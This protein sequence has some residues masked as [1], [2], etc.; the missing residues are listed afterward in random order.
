M[1]QNDKPQAITAAAHKLARIIYTM[2]TRDEEYVGQGQTY[3]EERY[4]QR[5]EIN[6][7][8]KAESLGLRLAPCADGGCMSTPIQ[9]KCLGYFYWGKQTD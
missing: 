8:R 3:Y 1:R 4:R 9:I 7:R 5:L 2:I 6:L